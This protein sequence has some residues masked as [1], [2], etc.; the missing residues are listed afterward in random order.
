M[1]F[2][3]LYLFQDKQQLLSEVENLR[4]RLNIFEQDKQNIT[5]IVAQKNALLSDLEN[6]ISIYKWVFELVRLMLY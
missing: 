4:S 2:C 6:E 3:L 1:H 5:E